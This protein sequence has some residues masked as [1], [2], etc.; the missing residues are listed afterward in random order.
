MTMQNKQSLTA[1]SQKPR[2]AGRLFPVPAPSPDTAHRTGGGCRSRRFP[3]TSDHFAVVTV[4]YLGGAITRGG[5]GL[6]WRGFAVALFGL[7]LAFGMA[8]EAAAQ[9]SCATTDV[10]IT[11]VTPAPTDPAALAGDCTTLLGLMDALRGT[12]SLNWAN[13]LSMTSW[14]GITVT[15]SRVTAIDLRSRQLDGTIPAALNNL[16]GLEELYL[17]SNELSGAIPDISGLT[18]LRILHLNNNRLSGSIPDLS[19]L[20]NLTNLELYENQLSGPIPDLS[21]LTNLLQIVLFQNQLSGSIPDLSSLTNL[22]IL[23]L[24]Q[25]QLSGPIPDLSSLSKLHTLR[26][27]RNQLSGPI[28]ELSALTSLQ[29]LVLSDNQLTGTIPEL[30]ALTSLQWLILKGNQLTGGIPD[31]SALTS[32]TILWLHLNQLSGTLPTWWGSLSSLQRLQLAGNPFTGAIPSELDSLTSLVHL[33]LCGTNLDAAATLPSALETRRTNGNLIVWPCLRIEDAQATEGQPLDFAVEHSTWP[34]RG[35]A[36]ASALTLDYMTQNGT[37]TSDDYRGTAAG[38]VTVPANTDTATW[39]SSAT[40][41]VPTIDDTAGE[42]AETMKVTVGDVTGVIVLRS[43]ATGTIQDNDGG[44][45]PPP[46][47]NRPPEVTLSCAP[48][49]VE[50]GGEALLTATAS[51]PDNDP[52]S[53]SWRASGGTFAGAADTATVRWTAAATVGAVTIRVTVSDGEGGRDSDWVTVDVVPVLP[54]KLSFDIPDRGSESFPTADEAEP[55]RVGYGQIRPDGGRSTPSGMALFE[56]RGRDGVLITEEA[57]PA[58]ELVPWG[59]IFAEVGGPVRTAVAFANPNG[60]PVDIDFY[61]TDAGGNRIAEGSFR[62]EAYR[63]MAGFLSEE[64]YNVESVVGTFTF[65]ASARVAVMA[66]WEL[67]NAP[68]ECLVATLPVGPVLSPPSPFSGTSTHPVVF[69]HFA[70]GDGWSTD[71]ILVNP[72]G[73]SIAG[74]LEFLGPDGR[75]E[76]S[77]EYAIARHSAQRFRASNPDGGGLA[78][79]WVRARPARGAAPQGVQLLTFASDGKTV[80]AAGVAATGASTAFRVPV[81]EAGMLGEPGSIRTGL[82]V[83]NTTDEEISLS[84]EITRP[85]GSLVTPLGSLTLGPYGQTSHMLDAILD[86][87]EEFSSGML[88]V[89]ATGPVAVAGLRIR[90]NERGELKA[91]SLWPSNELAGATTRDRYFAHLADVHGWTTE[92]VLFSGTVGETSSGNLCLFWFPVE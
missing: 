85:D 11:G 54:E 63:H 45:Q 51:D 27:D 5:V 79:G 83:A 33:S 7:G 52:L 92:L 58:S 48:C 82:A 8:S 62:L 65:R 24:H 73:E 22:L 12:A 74:T 68:G 20:T 3:V 41:S 69:P 47:P 89:S 55:P 50:L 1:K 30:S 81:E 38:M 53:Y 13:S 72:T 2:A 26:L 56:L 40:I 17:F 10:A 29:F 43:T 61:V 44:V 4:R 59:R 71:V 31:L 60:R 84:L 77:F 32:L 80:A 49:Q 86:L 90:I 39:T 14:D 57:V 15:G 91:T 6:R 66:F 25:N 46:S 18:S 88:R 28:P 70:D 76:T 9:T 21:A 42:A 67:I 78:S 16:T 37:A 19:S 75:V 23:Q 87:P 36:S 64:P 35:S 34:V